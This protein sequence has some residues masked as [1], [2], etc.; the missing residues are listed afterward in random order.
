MHSRVKKMTTALLLPHT[1][2][3][4]MTQVRVSDLATR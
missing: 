4:R 2:F 1:S 3:A